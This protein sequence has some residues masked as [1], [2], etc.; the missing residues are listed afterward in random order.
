MRNVGVN[1][2]VTGNDICSYVIKSGC[3]NLYSTC[4][5]AFFKIEASDL[6][7]MLQ[8]FAFRIKNGKIKPISVK[9]MTCTA[10]ENVRTFFEQDPCDCCER[11]DCEEC[12]YN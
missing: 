12:E 2:I 1:M 9:R 4:N 5:D 11:D 10:D 7:S 6:I 8:Y 3:I